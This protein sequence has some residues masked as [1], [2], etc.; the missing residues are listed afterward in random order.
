[1]ND[2]LRASE[3]A[4]FGTFPTRTKR[5]ADGS[6]DEWKSRGKYGSDGLEGVWEDEKEEDGVRGGVIRDGS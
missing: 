2:C 5:E 3:V 1:M 6:G 4:D